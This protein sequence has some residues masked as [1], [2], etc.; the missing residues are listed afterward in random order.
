[1]DA[2]EHEE[3][4]VSEKIVEP[5]KS[6]GVRRN[7]VQSVSRAVDVLDVLANANKP[8]ATA[9]IAA[10]LGLDR[11]VVHR[12]L[13]TLAPRGLV[14]EDRGQYSLGPSHV[15]YS[16]RYLDRLLFRKIS[17]PY[18][19]D[20]QNRALIGKPWVTTLAIAR[21]D[22]VYVTD[23]IWTPSTS[24]SAILELGEIF[25][26]DESSI[27]LC[28][29]AYQ[30]LTDVKKV[31]GDERFEAVEPVLA[32][33]RNN[34]GIALFHSARRGISG[35]SAPIIDGSSEVVGGIGF[36]GPH[37]ENDLSA[38]SEIAD[39]LRITASAISRGFP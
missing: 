31:L 8:L 24:L 2:A 15:L 7:Q 39:Q 9:D 30:D 22:S 3:L 26:I 13:R 27:G 25:P 6:K 12:L 29:L 14:A 20:F 19:V 16:N 36:T 33:I 35:M 37:M 28:M 17:L 11:T 4:V 38:S 5:S 32:E 23:R 1:M 18:A 34:G 10:E 21:E